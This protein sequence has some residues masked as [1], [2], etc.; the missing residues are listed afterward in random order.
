MYNGYKNKRGSHAPETRVILNHQFLNNAH[1]QGKV[2]PYDDR[3]HQQHIYIDRFSRKDIALPEIQGA[4]GYAYK[5]AID[6]QN[7][8]MLAKLM[9][10]KKSYERMM[11]YEDGINSRSP[12]ALHP[13][14]NGQA[15]SHVRSTN[16]AQ[17]I[18]RI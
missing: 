9:T 5:S 14:L 2:G 16:N 11:K 3:R 4:R 18:S 13:H 7:S 10:R 12:N 15:V 1:E 17:G 8:A 6:Q